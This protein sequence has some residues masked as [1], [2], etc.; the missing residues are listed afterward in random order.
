MSPG[1]GGCQSQPA[2]QPVSKSQSA[3]EL[4]VTVAGDW[5]HWRHWVQLRSDRSLPVSLWLYV[6]TREPGC[7]VHPS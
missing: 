6:T 4:A 3:M 7:L 1:R 5:P 2:S